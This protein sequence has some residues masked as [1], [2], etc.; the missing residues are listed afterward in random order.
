M[1]TTDD[2]R[3]ARRY[4]KRTLWD[5][6]I[7]GGLAVGVGVA[8]VVAILSGLNNSNPPA[9]AMVRSFTVDSP[10]QITVELVVQRKEPSKTAECKLIAQAGG[11][12]VVGE[13]TVTI[14]PDTDPV[15][16]YSFTV[17]TVKEPVSIDEQGCRIVED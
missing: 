7:Y 8:I 12:E 9:V 15:K 6:L 1:T 3:I 11:Y 5:Y 14:P 10:T 13:T 2:A 17:T 4:P 16:P